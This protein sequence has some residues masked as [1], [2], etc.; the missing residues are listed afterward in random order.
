[1]GPFTIPFEYISKTDVRVSLDGTNL[2]Y[3][4]DFTFDSQ[5]VLRLV[6]NRTGLI[7]IYR[8]T[9]RATRLVDFQDAAVLTEDDL[10][11]ANKQALF[12][13]LESIDTALEAQALAA[14][15]AGSV[16]SAAAALAAA[17]TAVTTANAIAGVAATANA[18]AAA[19]VATANGIAATASSALSTANAANTASGTASTNANTALSTANGIAATAASAL[20]TANAAASAAGAAQTAATTAGTTA[21]AALPLVKTAYVIYSTVGGILSVVASRGFSTITRI[22]VGRVSMTLST[23]DPRNC[24]FSIVSR[25]GTGNENND[26]PTVGLHRTAMTSTTFEVQVNGAG[27]TSGFDTDYTT[28]TVQDIR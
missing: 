8:V 13:S 19:A 11:T 7:K 15:L 25:W 9:E 2:V 5:Y 10:D 24:T 17:N 20:S 4:T 26:V 6:G 18:N 27:A 1:M 3:L 22:S 12:V 16:G 14:S 21:D 28:V 23:L